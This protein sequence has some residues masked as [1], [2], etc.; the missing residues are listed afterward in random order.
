MTLEYGKV[1]DG[2]PAMDLVSGRKD[3]QLVVGAYIRVS[4]KTQGRKGTST[5][6]QEDSCHRL[7]QEMGSTLDPRY[8]WVEMETGAYME[9]PVLDEVRRAVR[10]R[11]ID[12][13][14]IFE[15]DRLSRDMIDP[16]LF[17][18]ECLEAGV[19]IRFVEGT[20]DT[21]LFGQF[22][23]LA[24][25]F[26]AQNEWI[27]IGK[28]T[29]TGK[30]KVASQGQRLPNGTGTGLFGYD[31]DRERKVRVI[32]EREAAVVRMMFQ[33]AADGVNTNRIAVWLNS[34][35]IR[36]KTGKLWSQ[37]GVLRGLRNEAYTG[38]H[39]YGKARY[40]KL[41]GNKRAVTPAPE[42]EWYRIEGF[43]PPL[44]TPEFFDM[45]QKKL[46][47]RQARWDGKTRRHLM[48][49]FTRCG[50]CGGPVTGNMTAKGYHYYR[51][52]NAI[53]HTGRPATCH[54]LGIRGDELEPLAWELVAGA[55]RNPDII[56]HEISLHAATG[57]GDLGDEVKRLRREI[58][59][60]KAEEQKL[61]G[62]YLKDIFS[63]D[64]LEGRAAQVKLALQEKEQSLSVLKE[65]QRAKEDAAK[66]GE[67]VAEYCQR[68]WEGMD[69]LDLEGRRAL[70][71]AFDVKAV[72][73]REEL[74]ITITVDPAATTMSPT[75][76]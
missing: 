46:A 57:Q 16:V 22:L 21:S 10:N 47:T 25:G 32:N 44:V 63:Q 42:S 66:S 24:A 14:I 64:A 20:S 75:S 56:S 4:T 76:R 59:G 26:A 13:L 23:M 6:T 55:I 73:T 11:D 18:R 35:D 12:V 60:L 74:Q 48:T 41:R 70:F 9:R 45:V 71:S 37:N 29:Q 49:G 7:A 51:C 15:Q 28:R 3:D 62:D 8:I 39:F 36:T 30:Q 27:Q 52:S 67:R 33:W 72:A 40:R 19:E 61:L 34:M 31:Y 65:Q 17:V 1:P 53:S 43:T 58:D 50:K 2:T 5:E 68:F 54:A 69:G 38:V